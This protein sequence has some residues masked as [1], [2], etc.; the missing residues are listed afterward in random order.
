MNIG[1]KFTWIIDKGGGITY[2]L[3]NLY[4][5][6]KTQ[7]VIRYRQEGEIIGKIKTEKFFTSHFNRLLERGNIIFTGEKTSEPTYQ[8]FPQICAYCGTATNITKHHLFPTEIR[9]IVGVPNG[10]R[11]TLIRL[12]APHHKVLHLL[13]TNQE[14][15]DF[16]H[17]PKR[18]VEALNDYYGFQNTVQINRQPPQIKIPKIKNAKPKGNLLGTNPPKIAKPIV[19]DLTREEKIERYKNLYANNHGY[20]GEKINYHYT[21]VSTAVRI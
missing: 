11:S 3:E 5:Y 21:D 15:Y 12:C 17:T 13:K 10:K 14:L 18:I 7:F 1:D 2:S 8:I 16:C 6:S 19:I 20:T 4:I 9:S